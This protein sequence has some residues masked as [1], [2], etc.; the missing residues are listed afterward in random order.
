[1]RLRAGW[2]CVPYQRP[3]G[4]V[5]EGSCVA[6]FVV[7]AASLVVH[8]LGPL[9]GGHAHGGPSESPLA[10]TTASAVEA[11]Q[12][13]LPLVSHRVDEHRLGADA[14]LEDGGSGHADEAGCGYLLPPSGGGQLGEPPTTGVS[15]LVATPA[16]PAAGGTRS[17]GARDPP[18]LVR[19]LQVIRI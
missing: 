19:E 15:T 3:P 4:Q 10:S 14:H 2:V 18:D 8:L 7:A 12:G 6:A 1:M 16:S 17:V 13:S 5:L 11:P 9:V